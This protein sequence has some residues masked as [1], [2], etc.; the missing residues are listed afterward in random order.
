[1]QYP[2]IDKLV[3]HLNG[4]PMENP[5]RFEKSSS[6]RLEVVIPMQVR[7]NPR[8]DEMD[9]R[10]ASM[11]IDD[12]QLRRDSFQQMTDIIE[13]LKLKGLVK[14]TDMIQ[15]RTVAGGA[16]E[17]HMDWATINRAG[18]DSIGPI[19]GGRHVEAKL[20]IPVNEID[21][22]AVIKNYI[23]NKQL[24]LM[25]KVDKALEGLSGIKVDDIIAGLVRSRGKVEV[26]EGMMSVLDDTGM[27]GEFVY[28]WNQE[29]AVK[30]ESGQAT[31]L[32]IARETAPA[33][34]K[35]AAPGSWQ[36]RTSDRTPRTLE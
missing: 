8:V 20:V 25:T 6:D 11:A 19:M 22:H 16:A 28:A 31:P 9:V 2:S 5:I 29:A 13:E 27:K 10:A 18:A 34:D 12:Q 36:D 15:L 7:E 1:M 26:V 32:V 21:E 17:S 23:F 3:K 35:A 24:K 4:I 30:K 33:V 14:N